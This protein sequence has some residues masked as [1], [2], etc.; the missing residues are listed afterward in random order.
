MQLNGV[1]SRPKKPR[2][3]LN[4]KPKQQ[5]QQRHLL[6]HKQCHTKNLN[7][8]TLNDPNQQKVKRVGFLLLLLFD[9]FVYF[10]FFKPQFY[11]ICY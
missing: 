5:Q 6:L 2:K 1:K 7:V 4:K 10:E 3:K 8:L 11:S 9:R